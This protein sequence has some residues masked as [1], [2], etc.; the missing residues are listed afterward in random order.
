MNRF[1]LPQVWFTQETL[2]ST[3]KPTFFI[4]S[5][6]HVKFGNGA[7]CESDWPYNNGKCLLHKTNRPS[8]LVVQLVPVPLMMTQL[9]YWSQL[10]RSDVRFQLFPMRCPSRFMVTKENDCPHR[11]LIN[12]TYLWYKSL[13][14]IRHYLECMCRADS[15]LGDI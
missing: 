10:Q 11:L 14:Q 15:G 13:G 3:W 8:S 12:R 6:C 1:P 5:L 2:K 9:F 7:S 4:I